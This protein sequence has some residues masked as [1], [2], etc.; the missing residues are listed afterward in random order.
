MVYIVELESR[1]PDPA[2]TP[3]A[4][5]VEEVARMNEVAYAE[6]LQECRDLLINFPIYG[7][8][9]ALGAIV[10]ELPE[11]EVVPMRRLSSVR[12]IRP[13]RVHQYICSA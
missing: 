13:S 10:V 4:E 1:R 8:L 7:F 3:E 5:F 2:K 9:P 12:D 11:F 6:F